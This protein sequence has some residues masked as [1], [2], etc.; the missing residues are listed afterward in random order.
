MGD[1]LAKQSAERIAR[2][3]IGVHQVQNDLKVEWPDQS[4]DD[5]TIANNVRESLRRDPYIDAGDIRVTTE[6]AHVGLYGVVENEFEKK[7]AQWTASRQ[8]GVVHVDNSL[9][10]RAKWV[11]KSDADISKDLSERLAIT[12]IDPDNQVTAK[13]D[14][15][16]A[17]LEGSVDSWFMWQAALDQALAAGAREPHMMI[18]VRYGEGVAV[19]YYGPFQ[20]VPQ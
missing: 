12:F 4:P 18:E 16:V 8:V 13:V 14:N 5:Q 20:Y 17:L 7:H 11:R 19:P 6:D 9:S 15:G 10:V 1:L 2:Y 3:T